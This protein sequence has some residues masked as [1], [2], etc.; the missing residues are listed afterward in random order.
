MGHWTV[1]L[2]EFYKALKGYLKRQVLLQ[3]TSQEI[4]CFT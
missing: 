1:F 2:L 4:I 3:E